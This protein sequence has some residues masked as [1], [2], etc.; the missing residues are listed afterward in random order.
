LP[1]T[2]NAVVR[3]DL[4]SMAG[5]RASF[6]KNPN[7]RYD[8]REQ[9]GK[10]SYGSVYKAIEV[11]TSEVV[12]VKVIPLSATEADGFAEIQKE[13]DTLKVRFIGVCVVFPGCMCPEAVPPAGMVAPGP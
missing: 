11:A 3:C 2:R 8:L 1:A 10:G 13:I 12:A 6:E 5:T 4:N 9:L 7:L